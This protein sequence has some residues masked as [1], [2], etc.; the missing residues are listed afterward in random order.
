MWLR[1][2]KDWENHKILARFYT[3]CFT[4]VFKISFYFKETDAG[5]C[6][7][8]IMGVVYV[9][10]MT[11]SSSEPPVRKEKLYLD[12]KN[13][14]W[15]CMY[16]FKLKLNRFEVLCIIFRFKKRFLLKHN[17]HRE[18]CTDLGVSGMYFY[19][20]NTQG[21]QQ[22]DQEME[23]SST[24]KS[25]LMPFPRSLHLPT[26][27]GTTALNFHKHRLLLPVI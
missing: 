7:W 20:V 12:Q 6:R 27:N 21:I 4:R 22:P 2:W 24:L 18:K 13:G 14:E 1:Q 26:S 9:R 15:M 16:M 8:C 3:H 10:K 25:F 23:F 19:K 11:R 5:N 17:I